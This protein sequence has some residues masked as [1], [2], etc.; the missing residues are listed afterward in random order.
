MALVVLTETH[1]PRSLVALCETRLRLDAR[2]FVAQF[3]E[4][5]LQLC[6]PGLGA[7]AE[8]FENQP[9][10]VDDLRPVGQSLAHIV[11]LVRA[12]LVVED[13]HPGVPFRDGGRQFGDF[14]LAELERGVFL[15]GLCDRRGDVV[16][17]GASQLGQFV[18][19]GGSVVYP[20]CEYRFHRS[21]FRAAYAAWCAACTVSRSAMLSTYLKSGSRYCSTIHRGSS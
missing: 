1:E 11:R 18:H 15:S 8:D 17:R 7:L 13:D 16:A 12:E 9:E 19:R 3:R 20:F 6:L 2:E 5:D 14:P 10:P 4:F 21:S